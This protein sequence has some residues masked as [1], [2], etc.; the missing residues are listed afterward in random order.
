MVNTKQEERS[1]DFFTRDK[2]TAF[3][4]K[5]QAQWIAFGPVVFQAAPSV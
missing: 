4:A 2:K 3:E 5:E 1:M